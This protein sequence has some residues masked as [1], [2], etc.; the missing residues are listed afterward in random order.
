M[1]EEHRPLHQRTV[2]ITG[3]SSGVGEHLAMALAAQGAAVGLL[4]RRGDLLNQVRERVAAEGGR[5]AAAQADVTD[6]ASIASAF[7]R[8]EQALGRF[9]SVIVNAGV[10][11]AGPVLRAQPQQ[12]A[13]TFAVNLLGAYL[14]AAEAGRR[15]VAHGGA[16][17]H[18]RIV[19]ISSI[20]AAKPRAG[21]ADYCASKAGL[22]MLAQV[23]ALE[24]ARFGVNVNTICPGYMPTDIIG[25]WFRTERGQAQLAGWPRKRVMPIEAL[26]GMVA[27]LLSPGALYTTGATIVIDDGQSI[28]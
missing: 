26:T 23:M 12:V 27:H 15:L 1:G 7:D 9:D 20:L 16:A 8:I 6:A 5:A 24:L 18:G 3:A 28:G 19:F 25:D 2:V 21:S 17:D 22:V 11:G 10:N 4:A 14:T 13:A